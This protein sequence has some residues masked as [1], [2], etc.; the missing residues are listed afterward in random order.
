MQKPSE[1]HPWND[2]SCEQHWSNEKLSATLVRSIGHVERR[3]EDK[4]PITEE[5]Y[6]LEVKRK[7]VGRTDKW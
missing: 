2:S 5:N 1:K 6:L 4:A 7:V 3:S